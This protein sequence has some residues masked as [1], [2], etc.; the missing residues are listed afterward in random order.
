MNSLDDINL[1]HVKNLNNI[2]ELNLLNDTLNICKLTKNIYIHYPP[3][4]HG[5]MN[6]R[7]GRAKFKNYL[8]LLDSECSSTII[9]KIIITNIKTKED[10]VMNWN[11][12]AGNIS[13][14]LKDKIDLTLPEF[15]VTKITMW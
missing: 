13:I 11:T 5:C 2:D 8:I 4:L 7:R 6:A 14:D 1:I 10:A 15:S 12:Q 3:I 9:T